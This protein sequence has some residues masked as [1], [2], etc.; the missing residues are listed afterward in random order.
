MKKILDIETINV[1]NVKF[2]PLTID[3]IVSVVALWL[4]EGRKGIHLTGVNADTVVLAQEDVV[5]RD[6]IMNSDIVNIDSFLPAR[7]LNKLGYKVTGRVPSPDVFEALLQYADSHNQKVYFFGATNETLQKLVHVVQV[8]FPNVNVVGTRNG[9]YSEQEE[10]DIA[11]EIS[12]VIPDYLFLGMPSPKKEKFILKYKKRINVGCF[13]GVGGAFDAMA[14]V[15]SRPPKWL[16]GYGMEGILR[17][18][19]NPSVYGK[20]LPY[21][22]KFLWIA[23]KK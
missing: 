4:K 14:G 2:N 9:Y 11:N 20:R 18:L 12:E 17:C 8:K 3:E 6:A 21:Y 1:W 13:Y 19:R 16:R 15:L 22:I 7:A 10:Q 5:L 23:R